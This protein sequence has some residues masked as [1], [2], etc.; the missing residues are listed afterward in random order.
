M[1]HAFM[2]LA[3]CHSSAHIPKAQPYRKSVYS[4]FVCI[5]IV[6]TVLQSNKGR[7]ICAPAKSLRLHSLQYIFL[8]YTDRSSSSFEKVVR[9]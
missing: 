7:L 3:H 8:Q 2:F 1:S 4:L 5:A 9:W 6:P